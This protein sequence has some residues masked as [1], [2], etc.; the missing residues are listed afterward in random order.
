MPNIKRTILYVRCVRELSSPSIP[1]GSL[2]TPLGRCVRV[3]RGWSHRSFQIPRVHVLTLKTVPTS[4]HILS[5]VRSVHSSGRGTLSV[6]TDCGTEGLQ[7]AG[8]PLATR[9][10]RAPEDRTTQKKTEE[11]TA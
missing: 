11:D 3:S 1:D 7:Y 6:A 2:A 5:N 9:L 4:T 10:N 8:K